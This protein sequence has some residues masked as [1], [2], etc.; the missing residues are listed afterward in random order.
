MEFWR[1]PGG[2][3]GDAFF[4][5]VS[6]EGGVGERGMEIRAGRCCSGGK[7]GVKLRGES[8]IGGHSTSCCN[9]AATVERALIARFDYVVDF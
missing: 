1:A 4:E 5:H 7:G 3:F 9:V 6:G 2:Q 8:V